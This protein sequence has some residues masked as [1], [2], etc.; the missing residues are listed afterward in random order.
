MPL[1]PLSCKR[2]LFVCLSSSTS[3]SSKAR[4]KRETH[5]EGFPSRCM[6]PIAPVLYQLPLQSEVAVNRIKK[7]SVVSLQSDN[8]ST[9]STSVRYTYIVEHLDPEIGPWSTLEYAAIAAECSQSNARFCLSSVPKTLELPPQLRNL[10]D[11]SVENR[12]VEEVY[13][14]DKQRVCLLDPAAE[15]ELSP[16]DAE[17]F[18]VFLFGGILGQGSHYHKISRD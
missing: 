18:H 2:V 14:E 11:T 16:S 17:S 6:C 5:R 9:A 13:Q 8:M 3:F 4:G 12:S 15:Q 7:A 10:P 1:S